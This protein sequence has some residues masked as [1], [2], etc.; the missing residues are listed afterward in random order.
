MDE[1]APDPVAD[2][3]ARRPER[4]ALVT[5]ETTLTWAD[6]NDRVTTTAQR[7]AESAGPGER[8]TIVLRDALGAPA[9]PADLPPVAATSSLVRELP[10]SPTGKVR[11]RELHP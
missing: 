2:A 9:Q 7:V 11:K 5:A 6:L 4:P 3:A 8:V 1:R 10:H